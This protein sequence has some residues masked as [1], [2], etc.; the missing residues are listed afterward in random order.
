[1]ALAPDGRLA[2]FTLRWY[3]QKEND[4]QSSLWVVPTDGSAPPHRLTRGA[5]ADRAPAFSPDGRLLAFLSTREDEPEVAAERS[6]DAEGGKP[7]KPKPQVWV[8]DLAAGGEPRQVTARE[9][10]VADFAWSPDGRCLV[11]AARDPTPAQRRYL[12]AI[13]G[14]DRGPLLT[15]RVQHK[16][17]GRGYLDDVRTHL[18]VVDV[19]TRAERRLTD[20][21]C[22]ELEPR[23]SPD[24]AW[25]AFV[26]NRTGDADNNR[27]SDLWLISPAG[28]AK[29]RL[30]HGDV[31]ARSPRWSPDG[32]RLAFVSSL[33]PEDAYRLQHLMVVEVDDGEPLTELPVGVGWS[34]VGGIVPD[35]PGPDPVAAARVY[36]VPLRRTPARVLT[37]AL[38][39][40]VVGAPVWLDAESLLAPVGDRGQ[41]VLVRVADDGTCTRLYPEP[42]DRLCSLGLPAAA[43]GVIV[44]GIDRPDTGMDLYRLGERPLRLTDVN[45]WLR[46][47][48][49]ASYQWVQFRDHDGVEVEALV[50]R[51]EHPGPHPLLVAI[52]GGPMA[53]DAPVFRFDR[54]YWA[55]TQG[56]LVLM[57]NYRGSTSYGEAFCRSIQGA[58]GPREHDDVMCGVDHVLERGWADPD[59]LFCTGFSQGGIMTNWAVGHTDRFRAAASEHGMWDYVAAYGT[60]DC[61]LWWQDDLGVPWQNEA[62]YRR[63]SP[64]AAAGAIRTPLLITAGELDWRCPLSQAEQLYLTLKKRGVPTQ[65]VIYQG[66]HHAITRPRRA[67]DRLIRIGRWL[68]RYGGA[69]WSDA[70][71]EGYPDPE[72]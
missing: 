11:V 49:L 17:D 15:A 23:W 25:I 48:K 68:A 46:E 3:R 71:A 2:A 24:G 30:T 43:G 62:G 37:S 52:H 44:A 53:Y 4:A 69:P 21:P 14:D 47:R 22:D 34:S 38:D 41:T 58:W 54:Q 28:D 67:I 1:V 5:T 65:L 7:A 12:E 27:R 39:R 32:R 35:D 31:G 66:E 8:L 36:P 19:A 6:R 18:F 72:P 26:S 56:Y 60:D 16:H 13:R 50:A 29:R 51:P 57:V 64:M 40:P 63:I 42:G 55:A 45:P 70:S 10:G 33:A 9:E 20:G 59:R 61:H